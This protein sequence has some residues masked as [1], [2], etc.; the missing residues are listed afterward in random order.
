MTVGLI[1]NQAY[2]QAATELSEDYDPTEYVIILPNCGG[3]VSRKYGACN[4]NR[5]ATIT[6]VNGNSSVAGSYQGE[7]PVEAVFRLLN[8]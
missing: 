8:T 3:F 5:A 2:D 4:T 1:L 6:V 7:S